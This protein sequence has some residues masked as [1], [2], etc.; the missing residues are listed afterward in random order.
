MSAESYAQIVLPVPVDRAFTYAIPGS[1]VE[2]A[3]VGMRAVVPVKRRVDTGYIVALHGTTDVDGVR[4]IIDLPDETPVFS[5]KMLRLCR[6]IADYYCCSWGEALQCAVPAGLK[7]GTKM[8]YTLVEEGIHSGRFT[9]RQRKVIAE[10]FK[11]GPLTEGQLATMVGRRALSN[12]L[13]SLTRRGILLAE[14][15]LKDGGV[16]IR[17]ETYVRLVDDAVPDGPALEAM[18]RRAPKQSAVYLDLL[19]T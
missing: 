7:I 19:H 18:Q 14:P 1:L 13:Q 2:R 3:R 11:R 12:T 4:S 17:T 10:L 15:V 9:D 16:S 8:R 5:E 6:W